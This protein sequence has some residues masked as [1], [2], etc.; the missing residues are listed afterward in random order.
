MARSDLPAKASNDQVQDFLRK[1]AM[2]PVL[3][4]SE[5]KGRLIFALD[6]TA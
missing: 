3:K 1:V 5:E 6:A 2:T 4:T